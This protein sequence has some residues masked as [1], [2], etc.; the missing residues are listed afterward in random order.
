M[1]DSLLP[2]LVCVAGVLL[3]AIVGEVIVQVVRMFGGR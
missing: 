3:G 2:M 1:R